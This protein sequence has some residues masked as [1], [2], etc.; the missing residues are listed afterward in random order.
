[1]CVYV[2]DVFCVCFFA[3][4]PGYKSIFYYFEDLENLTYAFKITQRLD[5]ERC[6]GIVV[7]FSHEQKK[8]VRT[9]NE[10]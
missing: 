9:Y 4:E 10:H 3:P 8:V 1:M 2:Y 7:V 6:R 5:D